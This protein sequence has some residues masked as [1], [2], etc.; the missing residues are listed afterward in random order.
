MQLCVVARGGSE[1]IAHTFN[2]EISYGKALRL[3]IPDKGLARSYSLGL[4]PP[5]LDEAA[6]SVGKLFCLLEIVA[7]ERQ[8]VFIVLQ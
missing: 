6:T 1:A 7:V 8:L 5:G 2:A 3:C 4:P